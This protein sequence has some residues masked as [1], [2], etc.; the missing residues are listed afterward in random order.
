VFRCYA[1][2][3]ESGA[4]RTTA[5]TTIDLIRVRKYSDQAPTVTFLTNYAGYGITTYGVENVNIANNT[6]L[7]CVQGLGLYLTDWTTVS[8][9]HITDSYWYGAYIQYSENNTF[10]NNNLSFSGGYGLFT[11]YS[12]YNVISNNWVV[13]NNW[14]GIIAAWS[15]VGNNTIVNNHLLGN[16]NGIRLFRCGNNTLADNEIISSIGTAIEIDTSFDNTA[17]GNNL[18]NNWG[19]FRI[20][21]SYYNVIVGNN[22]TN[23]SAGGL[24]FLLQSSDNNR[25][26]HNNIDNPQQAQDTGT[27]SWDN[28]YPSGGNWWSDYSGVDLNTTAAQNVPPPDSLGDTPYTNILGGANQDNY[29]LMKPTI[30]G[31]VQRFPIRIDSNADFDAEHGVVNWAAGDGSAGNPW[32]IEGWDING[33]DYECCIYVGNTTEHYVIQNCALHNASNADEDGFGVKIHNSTWGLV[34]ECNIRYNE[35]RGVY[36]WESDN[37][38]ISNCN[39]SSNLRREYGNYGYGIS[40][41]SSSNN[42]IENCTI[43]DSGYHSIYIFWNFYTYNLSYCNRILNNTITD[44]EVSVCHA[45]YTEILSNHV[46]RMGPGSLGED[47]AFGLYDSEHSIIDGNT[48]TDVLDYSFFIR[49]PRIVLRNNE[50]INS[51]GIMLDMEFATLEIWN[52]HTIDS[53]N[54]IDGKPIYY[55]KNLTSGTAPLGAGE[56]ILANCTGVNVTNQNLAGG[57]YEVLVGYSNQCNI[58]DNY[59]EDRGF[60]SW[61]LTA[62]CDNL[63][64]KNNTLDQGAI[65]CFVDSNNILENNY[66]AN[67]ETGLYLASVDNC[68]VSNN[69]I[70]NHGEW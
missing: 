65:I 35:G 18:E 10:D 5:E 8:G 22:V 17:S 6:I 44:S 33:T 58:S 70:I 61:I 37:I 64:I 38:T 55:L 21:D 24:G 63:S 3:A 62:R 16:N 4:G 1:D 49:S 30:D 43:M 27:N 67:G 69:E 60:M 50:M 2:Y 45:P 48:V 20:D 42:T 7:D 23:C 28:G 15:N 54:T 52:T 32:I 39:V 12:C 13:S 34:Q 40:L 25:I 57:I 56:V 68:T 14:N 41:Y 51:G 66:V 46:S 31:R 59:F 9:N 11:Y 36:I 53:S 19:G 47:N 29:P 26:Y